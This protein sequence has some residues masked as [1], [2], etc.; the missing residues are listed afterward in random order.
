MK[1]ISA[2]LALAFREDALAYASQLSA[3]GWESDAEAMR[4]LAERLEPLTAPLK[5]RWLVT[6]WKRE[7]AEV[8]G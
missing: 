1:Q 8:A 2:R 6:D 3:M 4:D 7:L 5:N